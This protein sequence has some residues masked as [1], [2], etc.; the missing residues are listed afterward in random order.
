MYEIYIERTAEKDIKNLQ[1]E[2][3]DD[4]IAQI[5]ALSMTPRP[6]GCKKLAGSR[7]DWRIRTGDYRILYEIDD[8]VKIVRVMKVRHRREAYR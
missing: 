1:K 2:K 4:V 7:N 8:M 5:K 6:L 3:Q